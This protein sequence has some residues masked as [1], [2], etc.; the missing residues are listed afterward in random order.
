MTLVTWVIPVLNGMPFL[1]EALDSI[2]RQ[3]YQNHEVLVWDNGSTDGTLEVLREWIPHRLPGRVFEG[4]PLSLGLSLRRLVEEVRTPFVARMDADDINHTRRLEIQLEY[5]QKHQE[6]SLVASDRDG[7]DALGH[8]KETRSVLPCSSTALLHATLRA[9]RLLHPTV[10]MRRDHLLNVGNYQDLSTEEHP[11]W[12]EDFDLWQR[13]LARY[14]AVKLPDKL[15]TYR[16]HAASLTESEMR[17]QRSNTARRRAWAANAAVLAGIQDPDVAM[18]LWDRRL[19]FAA[20]E[21]IHIARHL[22]KVDEIPITKRLRMKSFQRVLATF[23]GQKDIITRLW[24]K[25]MSM[26]SLQDD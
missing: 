8:P 4:E 6:I 25:S 15:L 20:P 7:M 9:P 24:L 10:I 13:Y 21:F 26:V 22:Q 1:P 17:L 2:R 18:Q 11:Y 19:A 12:S 16:Y 5:L 3:T 14:R 23:I